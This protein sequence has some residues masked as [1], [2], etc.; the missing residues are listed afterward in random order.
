MIDLCNFSLAWKNYKYSDL[1][2]RFDGETKHLSLCLSSG[3]EG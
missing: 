1:A 2:G 3:G